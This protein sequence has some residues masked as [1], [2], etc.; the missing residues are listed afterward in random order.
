MLEEIASSQFGFWIVALLI[1]AVD[2]SFLLEPGKFAFSIS[3]A[4]RVRL[5]ISPAPFMLRNRELASS[6]V[7]FPFQLFFISDIRSVEQTRPQTSDALSELRRL[8]RQTM[9]FSALSAVT[10]MALLLGPCVAALSGIE[11]S[12]MLLFLPLYL[13][14]IAAS[15]L[16]WR[17][18]QRFG[19]SSN[20]VLRISA[21]IVFC[22]VLLVNISKRISL[23]QETRL[24]S[25]GLAAFTSTP[26]RTLSEIRDNIRYHNGD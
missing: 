1:A 15:V 9:I 12:I 11:K 6:L 5:R 18:R 16:L 21:E 26:D 19:L 24:N 17:K 10:T 2:S 23:A 8:S 7:C 20:T 13:L 22:P 14:A 4:N 3:A 25:Y